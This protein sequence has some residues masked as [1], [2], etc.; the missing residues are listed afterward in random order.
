MTVVAAFTDPDDARLALRAPG[1]LGT[2]NAA[3]VLNA[4][5]VHVAL[6]LGRFG[7]ETDDG[8]LLAAALAV[9]APRLGHVHVDLAAVRHTAT[10]DVD[11][12]VDLQA[13]PWPD[14]DGWVAAVAA[15]PLVAHG[16]EGPDDRPLRL[17]G[18]W[19]YLDRY[20]REERQV[21]ADLAL[22]AEHS[23]DTVDLAVLRAGLD[24]LFPATADGP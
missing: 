10:V 2:F 12:P 20:W 19:L 7:P 22:R 13:L 23:V 24:R 3:G 6:R 16:E 9:R 15:S 21:A 4:A 8:V 1:L 5:D 17:I 14:A 18:S 11:V